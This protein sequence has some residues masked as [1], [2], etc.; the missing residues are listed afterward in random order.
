MITYLGGCILAV[1]LMMAFE[2]NWT[3]FG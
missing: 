2:V 1:D 3:F